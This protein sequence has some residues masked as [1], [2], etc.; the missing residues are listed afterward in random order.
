MKSNLPLI[1]F[2]KQLPLPS[3]SEEKKIT[4]QFLEHSDLHFQD[5]FGLVD[6]L[7]LQGNRIFAYKIKG[8]INLP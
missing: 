5:L 8:C 2:T 1:H 6:R 7:H 4:L 3:Y